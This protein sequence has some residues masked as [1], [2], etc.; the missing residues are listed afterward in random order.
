MHR[1]VEF[2]GE[3]YEVIFG[4]AQLVRSTDDSSEGREFE[5]DPFSYSK[6]F[7]RLTVFGFK[8]ALFDAPSRQNKKPLAWLAHSFLAFTP[9]E[10]ELFTDLKIGE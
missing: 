9:P 1:N 10:P 6:M 8:P 2:G 4:W 7:P 5:M 3:R